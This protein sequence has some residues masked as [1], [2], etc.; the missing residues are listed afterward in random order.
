MKKQRQPV[1]RHAVVALMLS[2]GKAGISIAE[3]QAAMGLTYF[4]VRRHLDRIIKLRELT[5]VPVCDGPYGA[6][7]Y[8]VSVPTESTPRK[9]PPQQPGKPKAAPKQAEPFKSSPAD[10]SRAKVT[11]APP[12]QDRFAFSPPPGWMGAITR[13]WRERRLKELAA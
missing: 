13:D 6:R 9:V 3:I 10:Y 7:R 5:W 12:P 1:V 4:S 2:S 8:Y 11:I